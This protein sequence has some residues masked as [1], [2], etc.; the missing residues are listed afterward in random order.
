MGIPGSGADLQRL[1]VRIHSA[2]LAEDAWGEIGKD[3]CRALGADGASL[4]RP[5]RSAAVQPWCRLF[6]FDPLFVKEYVEHWG[7]QDVWYEGAVRRGRIGVGL[8]NVDNQLIDRSHFLESPFYNEYL[9]RANIDRMMNVC[10]TSPA[11]DD[12]FGPTAFSFFRGPGK[13]SFS[14]EEA[15][16]LRH[17][18]P[19]L[20]VA[21]QN[22]WA[23]QALRRLEVG[24]KNATD[25]VTSGLFAIEFSGRLAFANQAG[26][27]LARHQ[28][29][30][31]V[32]DK[33]IQSAKDTLEAA[34][35]TTALRRLS[36]GLS[37]RLMAT[38]AGTGAR[39]IVSGAPIAPL[40]DNAY[41]VGISAL[42]WVTPVI[43]NVDAATDLSKL[44]GFSLAER[45]LLARLIAGDDMRDAA[46][47][48][49]VSL[50]TART[51]L[52]S[53]FRKSG[54]RS[55]SAVLAL[56]ARLSALRP[57]VR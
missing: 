55:Q 26:T 13:D 18:A 54:L 19:H 33:V 34:S 29:W 38:Q 46:A 8:V 36:V 49:S 20:T 21:A 50:N 2:A 24:Y 53:I 17:L 16:L 47:A 31:A 28:R 37:F 6:E 43:P 42:V 56:A 5:N 35:L 57:P 27:E 52:K 12:S 3:L 45:R 22:Y 7:R 40:E 39:A 23:A 10:L 15:G 11:P 48:L 32:V 14:S 41:P 44:F 4:V 25:T 30:V 9:R 51:Q 1:I